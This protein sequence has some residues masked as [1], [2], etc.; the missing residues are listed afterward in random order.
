MI[1]VRLLKPAEQEML[2]AAQYYELQADGL[3]NVFLDKLDSAI[4]D[5]S[6]S[7]ES[8][9]VVHNNI[10]RRL[11]YRFPYTLLYRVDDNEIV[12]IAIMHLHRHPLYWIN[13]I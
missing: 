5:I 1:P 11:V 3:G 9:Q 6:L 7:P 10:R 2:D 4:N 8:W 12:I 13:R